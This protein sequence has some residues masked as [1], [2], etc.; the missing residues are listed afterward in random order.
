MYQDFNNIFLKKCTI[1]S[2]MYGIIKH[3]WKLEKIEINN[4]DDIDLY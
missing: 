3:Y 4:I 1:G 2:Y